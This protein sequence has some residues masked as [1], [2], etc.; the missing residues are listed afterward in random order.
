METESKIK[1]II[2][3]SW[4]SFKN[5]VASNLFDPENEKMMQ[6]QLAQTIQTLIPIFE[7][8]KNETIKVLLEI[9]VEINRNPNRRLI[10]IV[11]FHSMGINKKYFPIELK[12]FRKFVRDGSGKKRGAQNLG[13]FD[14]WAD[15]ENIEQYTKL[16]NYSFATQL[17]LTDDEY[18][19]SGKHEGKQVSVYSTNNSRVNISGNLEQ[20]VANRHGRIQLEGIYSMT[21]W[22]SLGNYS[23]IRQEFNGD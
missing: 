6:L 12:C 23:F 16:P 8:Q 15:I 5:K 13:M 10:D 9:P 7:F 19:V 22:E 11:I 20:D 18:Y 17:T 2:N 1:Q 3:I 14:Y 21:N 4:E